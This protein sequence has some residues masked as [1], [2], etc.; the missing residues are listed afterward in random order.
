MA[1]GWDGEKHAYKGHHP[2]QVNVVGEVPEPTTHYCYITGPHYH[3]FEP[4]EGMDYRVA[5]D[6]YFYVGV[7]SP[8]YLEARPQYIG[9]NAVYQPVVYTRP[10]VEVEPPT[11]WILM[12]P[13]FV[14]EAPTAAVVVGGPPGLVKKGA[15]VTGGVGVGVGVGVGIVVPPPPTISVGVGVHIGGPAVIVAPGGGHGKFKHGKF[16]RH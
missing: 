2:V 1:Y 4:P 12:Q 6:A 7:P 5:G 10:V 16:K 3:S 9:I 13:Q 8:L 11:G 15:V 14:V